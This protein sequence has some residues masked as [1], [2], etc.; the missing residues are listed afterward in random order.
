MALCCLAS[1]K[2]W[3][4]QEA[5]EF[6]YVT[7]Q[8]KNPELYESYLQ[9]IREYH[10][11]SH[12]I[13]IAGFDNVPYTP[14]SCA[15]RIDCF[16]DST[17]IIVLN[18]FNAITETLL[19]QVNTIRQTKG[20]KTIAG[21]SYDDLMKQYNDDEQASG[22][23]DEK[24]EWLQLNVRTFLRTVRTCDLD[25]VMFAF[26]GTNPFAMTTAEK[27]EYLAL[28]NA[29]FEGAAEY[30]E[31]HRGKIFIFKGTPKYIYNDEF[32]ILENADYVLINTTSATGVSNF[33]FLVENS[34]DAQTPC[35]NILISAIAIDD[36][37]ALSTEGKLSDGS[38][39]IIGAAQWTVQYTDAYNKAGI[40]VEHAQRDY[41][42]ISSNYADIDTAI[43]IMNPSPLK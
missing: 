10:K 2:Q 39:A 32:E 12:P 18:N 25:G 19:E 5:I 40:Y 11:S 27:E 31:T 8:E 23:L 24:V 22:S 38:S 15:E 30:I 20:I 26:S 7:I 35:E 6:K 21:I 1:C 36:S 14:A 42:G 3:T 17:D 13:L 4:K 33:S 28:Q 41:F 37:D 16:P 43:S 9:S 34:L 29:F